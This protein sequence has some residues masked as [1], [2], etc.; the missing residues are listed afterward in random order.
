MQRLYRLYK[1]RLHYYYKS[2]KCRNIDDERKKNPAPDLPQ[3]QWEYLIKY[4]GSDEFKLISARNSKNR[5]SD[6]RVK[7]TTGQKSFSESEDVLT[8]TNGGVKLSADKVWLIQHTRKNDD[9]KLEWLH[10]DTRSKGIH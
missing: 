3:S 6:K 4:Y 10:G 8:K 9:G 7:H 5:N 2:K 1:C